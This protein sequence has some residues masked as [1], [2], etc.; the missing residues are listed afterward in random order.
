MGLR[1]YIRAYIS[2]VG[3]S[4]PISRSFNMDFGLLNSAW[5]AP[6]GLSDLEGLG[7]SFGARFRSTPVGLYSKRIYFVY[8]ERMSPSMSQRSCDF[9]IK[10]A[11]VGAVPFCFVCT[12]G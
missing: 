10:R 2:R 9:V 3:Y 4:S 1:A 11:G 6:E 12:I 7:F 8:S 5:Q